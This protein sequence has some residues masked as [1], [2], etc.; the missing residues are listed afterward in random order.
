MKHDVDLRYTTRL[1]AGECAHCSAVLSGHTGPNKPKPGDVSVCSTCG[2]YLKFDDS[3]RLRALTPADH[4]ELSNSPE[5]AA[6]LEIL[7]S[8]VL[9]RRKV[10]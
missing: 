10:H 9:E 1:P 8:M 5:T 4:A 6:L 7:R 3:M 2:G